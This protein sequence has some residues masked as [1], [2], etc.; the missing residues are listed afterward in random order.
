MGLYRLNHT[1]PQNSK[2]AI[3]PKIQ[4]NNCI[5]LE[6]D[7]DYL[8]EEIQLRRRYYQVVADGEV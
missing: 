6:D 5:L 2:R 7:D 1:T 8:L 3:K 4:N